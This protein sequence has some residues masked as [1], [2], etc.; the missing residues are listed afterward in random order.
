[1]S[2]VV[3]KQKINL[4]QIE[5]LIQHGERQQALVN[6]IADSNAMP[7]NRCGL[8]R[9]WLQ[10]KLTLTYQKLALKGHSYQGS[11]VLT[12]SCRFVYS[13]IRNRGISLSRKLQLS[14]WALLSGLLPQNLSER[15]L[16]FGFD[17]APGS[18]I[19]Q[20]PGD[21]GISVS[22]NQAHSVKRLDVSFTLSTAPLCLFGPV[23]RLPC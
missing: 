14:G 13:V 10:L 16:I 7:V 2:S 6:S 4:N 12:T 19:K 18:G 21:P 3:V 17:L 20:S 15:V 8:E 1:M 5:K 9:H 11:S 23:S 22:G